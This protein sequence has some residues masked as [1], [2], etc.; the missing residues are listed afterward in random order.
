MIDFFVILSFTEFF[1]MTVVI[2]STL[3]ILLTIRHNEKHISKSAIAEKFERYKR[4]KIFRYS[5]IYIGVA[6][7][8][9]AIARVLQFLG[10]SFV[11]SSAFYFLFSVVALLFSIRLIHTLK[12]AKSK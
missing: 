9:F 1:F 3:Y 8:L 11:L 7:Y 4:E 12:Y 6:F 2:I 10:K 5:L